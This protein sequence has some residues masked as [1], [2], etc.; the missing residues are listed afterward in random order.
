MKRI[1][2]ILLAGLLI[3]GFAGCE[4][5]GCLQGEIECHLGFYHN[6]GSNIVDTLIDSTIVYPILHPD[7]LLVT[8]SE[9]SQGF[10]TI[11]NNNSDTTSFIIYYDSIAY[12]TLHLVY[13]RELNMI[14]HDCGFAHFFRLKEVINTTNRMDS[15]WIAHELVNYDNEE[16]IKLYY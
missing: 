10:S 4:S 5:P 13:E 1:F 7:E 12:D 3:G 11:L 6:N 2:F 15:I 9:K 8:Y 16:H 14:S